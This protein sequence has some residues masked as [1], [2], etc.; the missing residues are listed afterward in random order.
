MLEDILGERLKTPAMIA[1]SL[2]ITGVFLILIEHVFQTGTRKEQDMR[3]SDALIV[4]IAQSLAVIP[5]ISR[6]GSTLI[7]ALWIGLNRETAVRYSFLLSIPVIMGSSLLTLDDIQGGMFAAIG[8]GP[9]L[10]AFMTSFVCSIIG[11]VWLIDF[12]NRS[13]LIY[14]AIY[15]FV[16]ALFVILFLDPA[17]VSGG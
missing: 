13:R 7:A 9:L 11:I 15:C 17:A 6:S 3:P 16:A 1:G 14:F 10:A 4:G 2:A 8:W 12:L 5:G